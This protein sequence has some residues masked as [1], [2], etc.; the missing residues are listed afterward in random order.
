MNG[1]PSMTMGLPAPPSVLPLGDDNAAVPS[2]DDAAEPMAPEYEKTL[3]QK[4]PGIPV[5]RLSPHNHA[6][7]TV[8]CCLRPLG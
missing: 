8:L 2:D 5:C 4:V 1:S 7:K 3:Y 6:P